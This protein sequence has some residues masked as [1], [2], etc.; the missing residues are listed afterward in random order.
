MGKAVFKPGTLGEDNRSKNGLFLISV[1]LLWGLGI[2]TML[3]ST[4]DTAERIFKE[5]N[6]YYFVTRQIIFSAVGFVFFFV[7]SIV[8]L[9]FIRK[10]IGVG[11][12]VVLIM[13]FLPI[14]ALGHESHGATRWLTIPHLGRFQP[15][16]FAKPAVVLFLANLIDKSME[17]GDFN[18]GDSWLYPAIGLI[19]FTS[20]IILQK[21]LSTA[22]LILTVGIIILFVTGARLAWVIPMVVL[23]VFAIAIFVVMEPYRLNRLIAYLNPGEY[24]LS[25]DYQRN[26]SNYVI[27][28]GGFWGNGLGTGMTSL[29]IPEIQTDYIFSG[30]TNAMGLVGVIAYFLLLGFFSWRGYVISRGCGNRFAS[31]VSFGCTTMIMVQS[32]LNVGVVS[33]LFPTTGIPL[34]FFSAGGTSLISSFIMCGLVLNACNSDHEESV[35]SARKKV[36][37]FATYE[38]IGQEYE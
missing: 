2:F 20:V 3:I 24:T 28:A 14:V 32:I 8:P 27:S 13:C 38:G 30:W 23:G 31:Y 26:Q 37:G 33:G 15:S 9:K 35:Y 10:L 1:L 16:E 18:T 6:K 21:D 29:N 4:A 22:V 36:G 17:R 19:A 7:S 12:V 34:P 11:V 5:H 25:L